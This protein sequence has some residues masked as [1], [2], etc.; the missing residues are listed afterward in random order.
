MIGDMRPKVAEWER[1]SNDPSALERKAREIRE[2]QSRE[3][4]REVALAVFGPDFKPGYFEVA[5]TYG[6]Y[7]QLVTGYYDYGGGYRALHIT[8]GE[9]VY[10]H[11]R[12]HGGNSFFRYLHEKGTRHHRVYFPFRS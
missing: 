10:R 7:D 2:E 5:P 11:Y 8:P 9:N 12:W 1:L 4:I 3:K 6:G